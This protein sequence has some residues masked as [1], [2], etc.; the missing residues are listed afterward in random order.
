MNTIN[1]SYYFLPLDVV[2]ML[3]PYIPK[4]WHP[5]CLEVPTLAIVTEQWSINIRFMEHVID[6]IEKNDLEYF[7]WV[8][9]LA[10]LEDKSDHPQYHLIVDGFRPQLYSHAIWRRVIESGRI[11][12]LDHLRA[13]LSEHDQIYRY[14]KYGLVDMLDKAP[15]TATIKWLWYEYYKNSAEDI[16]SI[17]EIM[18]RR[19]N[20]LM[21]QWLYDNFKS[22]ISYFMTPSLVQE[23]KTAGMVDWFRSKSWSR[24]V[25]IMLS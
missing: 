24:E 12:L 18:I 17:F 7:D 13:N 20:T 15:D 21:L 9:D 3:I 19:K 6:A 2:R 8:I 23:I 14:S 1:T 16:L 25:T 4:Y 11:S 10:T 22:D 5:K